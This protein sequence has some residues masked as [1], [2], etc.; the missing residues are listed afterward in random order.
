MERRVTWTK[1]KPMTSRL[2]HFIAAAAAIAVLA[3]AAIGVL[4]AAAPAASAQGPV[5]FPGG[6]DFGIAA[7]GACGTSSANQG[8]GRPGTHTQVCGGGLTFVV[9]AI[10]QISSVVGPTVM[11][12][13]VVGSAI[14]TGNNITF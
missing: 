12:P 2:A 1:G 4:G 11:S 6:G 7:A 14:V 13:G 5:G 9:P 10:G 3:A 8:I